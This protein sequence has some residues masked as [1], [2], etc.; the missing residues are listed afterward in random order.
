[1]AAIAKTISNVGAETT[2]SYLDP[3]RQ[4]IEVYVSVEQYRHHIVNETA[5][6]TASTSRMLVT[7][8]SAQFVRPAF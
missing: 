3:N 7:F 5:V 8:L 4:D 2:G 1:M 6:I